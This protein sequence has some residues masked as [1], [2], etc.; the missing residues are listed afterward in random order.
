[1]RAAQLASGFFS[2]LGT[3]ALI[4]ACAGEDESDVD[5]LPDDGDMLLPAGCLSTHNFG[6]CSKQ[7]S[8]DDDLVLD[9]F[10]GA[11]SVVG[12]SYGSTSCTSKYVVDVDAGGCAYDKIRATRAWSTSNECACTNHVGYLKVIGERCVAG[13]FAIQ[14]SPCNLATCEGAGCTP[15]DLCAP[16]VETTVT[17]R[18]VHNSVANTCTVTAQIDN[19]ADA[20]YE[21][22]VQVHAAVVDASTGSKKQVTVSVTP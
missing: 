7:S 15:Q 2:M 17:A 19:T 21:G 5:A 1:M 12:T 11:E 14:G 9:V 6:S 3:V 10:C 22:D 13:C 20:W 8:N 16:N 18:G 4:G